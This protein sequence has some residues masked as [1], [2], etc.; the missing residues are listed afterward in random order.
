MAK[1]FEIDIDDLKKKFDDVVLK[2]ADY[3]MQ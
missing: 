1:R 3:K 2:R